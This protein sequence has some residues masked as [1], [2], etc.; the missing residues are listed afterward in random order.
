MTEQTKLQTDKKPSP[1]NQLIPGFTGG[2]VKI[3]GDATIT[4]VTLDGTV[5][6]VSSNEP[7]I[8]EELQ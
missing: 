4:A 5:I 7:V 6:V 1:I 2:T 3:T 8:S